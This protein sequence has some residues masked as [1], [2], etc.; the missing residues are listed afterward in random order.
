[1]DVDVVGHH[2]GPVRRQLALVTAGEAGVGDL[3]EQL[4]TRRQIEAETNTGVSQLLAQ[5]ITPAACRL[6]GHDR[7]PF[8]VAGPDHGATPINGQL[9]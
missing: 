7:A 9:R 6:V 3:V 5:P 8:S 1:M 4:S 2:K